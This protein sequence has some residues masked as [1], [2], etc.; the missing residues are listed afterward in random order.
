MPFP[1]LCRASHTCGEPVHVKFS[2]DHVGIPEVYAEDAMGAMQVVDHAN[3]VVKSGRSDKTA[4]VNMS[5]AV[6]K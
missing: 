5:R 6:L 1:G 4:L 2:D 3:E